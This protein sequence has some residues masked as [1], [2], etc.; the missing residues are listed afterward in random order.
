[1]A[2]PK[3]ERC[4]YEDSQLSSS[5]AIIITTLVSERDVADER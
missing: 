3:K 2:I 5:T 4:G 1:V